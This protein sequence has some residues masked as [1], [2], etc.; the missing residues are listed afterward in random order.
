M[1][2]EGSPSLEKDSVKSHTLLHDNGIPVE[3]QL[4]Y[5]TDQLAIYFL[6]LRM[7]AMATS[8]L[9][10]DNVGSYCRHKLLRRRQVTIL[11][12]MYGG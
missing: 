6:A 12:R 7:D 11:K 3:D 4:G 9:C 1:K 2:S 8:I 5:L 10:F